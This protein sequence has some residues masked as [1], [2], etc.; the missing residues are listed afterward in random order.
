MLQHDIAGVL[1]FGA[2][3][4][5]RPA[6]VV[7]PA[8]ELLVVF[9]VRLHV[10]EEARLLLERA[11]EHLIDHAAVLRLGR[12]VDRPSSLQL[13]VELSVARVLVINPV[14]LVRREDPEYGREYRQDPG[15][16]VVE[17]ER[18][19]GEALPGESRGPPL[20][21]VRRAA[22]RCRIGTRRRYAR[23]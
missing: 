14:S 7:G 6:V 3:V 19:P 23:L 1:D 17:P 20:I 10:R 22:K 18:V 13:S 2:I 8:D 15:E 21:Q 16:H 4:K 11:V 9:D 12:L 5:E